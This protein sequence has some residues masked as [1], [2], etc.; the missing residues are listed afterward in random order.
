MSAE[1]AVYRK[2]GEQ[3]WQEATDGLPAHGGSLGFQLAA[4]EAEPGVF[5][6]AN[7]TG[8]YRSPDGGLTWERLDIPWP[9]HYRRRHAQGMVVT[10]IS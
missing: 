7:N 9:E 10:G 5:Y 1:S 6:A 8:V 4:N 2:T 3:G